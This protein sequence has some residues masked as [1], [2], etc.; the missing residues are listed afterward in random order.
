MA[1]NVPSSE[2]TR[3]L[4]GQLFADLLDEDIYVENAPSGKPDLVPFAYASQDIGLLRQRNSRLRSGRTSLHADLLKERHDRQTGG[5]LPELVPMA[6]FVETDYFLY[7]CGE[8]RSA[9]HYG[10]AWAPWSTLYLQQAPNFLV[11]ALGATYAEQLL[12]PLGVPDLPTF[13]SRFAERV[14]LSRNL[15]GEWRLDN[16]FDDFDPQ[17]IGTR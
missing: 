15:F 13:R 11:K 7:L 10:I 9:Q 6:Q 3:R 1:P 2:G 16:P 5:A 8:L 14:P 17:R 12:K 4:P